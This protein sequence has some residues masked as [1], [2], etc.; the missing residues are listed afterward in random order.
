[1]KILEL[2]SF[3]PEYFV[4]SKTFINKFGINPT[5]VLSHLI[6]NQLNNKPE[7]I[8]N[9]YF[10]NRIEDISKSTTLSTNKIKN[11]INKLYKIKLID[12]IIKK[13]DK[14]Y[15]KILDTNIIKT[16]ITKQDNISKKDQL[17]KNQ[18]KFLKKKRFKKPT[19]NELKTYFLE[20]EAKTEETEIMFDYYESKGWKVGKA[21]MKC[22]KSAARNWKRRSE[23][24]ES[25]FPDYYDKEFEKK[26]GNDNNKVS[27]YHQH[28]RKIGWKSSYSPTAGTTWL[29]K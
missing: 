25:E 19:L 4:L 28:L 3:G 13:N 10:L 11:A 8:K 14:V 24:E 29:K 22:W 5:L 21:P 27:R 15:V 16:I 18:I 6:E 2:F 26:I 23:K 1:M 17:E 20:I 7:L 9:D 12:V